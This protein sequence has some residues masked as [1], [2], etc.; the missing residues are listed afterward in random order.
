MTLVLV[1]VDDRPIPSRQEI[2][3]ELDHLRQARRKSPYPLGIYTVP[4]EDIAK[5]ALIVPDRYPV[6][7]DEAAK[8]VAYVWDWPVPAIAI[9]LRACHD[10]AGSRDPAD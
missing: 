1:P 2:I 3:S 4:V 5:V 8:L 7:L 9:V 10:A 6:T